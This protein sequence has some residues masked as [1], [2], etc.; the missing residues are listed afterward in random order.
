MISNGAGK[1]GASIAAAK[2]KPGDVLICYDAKGKFH[3]I[4]LYVGNSQYI[5]CTNTSSDHIA[6]RPYSKLLGKYHVSRA[7]RYK[8]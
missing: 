6:V 7:F 4:A 8:K 1:G 2:L 3:H 5:D